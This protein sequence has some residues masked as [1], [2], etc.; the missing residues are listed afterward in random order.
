MVI[1][2]RYKKLLTILAVLSIPVIAYSSLNWVQYSY[3]KNVKGLNNAF[4]PIAIEDNEAS[5]LQ[6][7]IFSTSGSFKKRSGFT[8][9][10]DDRYGATTGIKYVKFSDGKEQI[11]IISS[12]DK[13]Y[14]MDYGSSG[15][16]GIL[17]DITGGLSFSIGQNNLASFAVGENTVVIE[18]GLNTTPPMA[19]HD[20]AVSCVTLAGS[21]PNATVVAYHKNQGFCAGNSAY[22]STLYFT[23]VGNLLNWTTGLSGNIDVEN[24]DGSIIRALV[25][26]FDALYIFKDNSIFRLTGDDKDNFQLQRMVQGIGV[27]SSQAV[28]LIG[29]QFFLTTGQGEVYIYDGAVGVTKISNK[30]EGSLKIN[31]AYSRYP[32]LSTLEYLDDYYLSVSSSSSGTNDTV[33]MFDTFNMA[34]TKFSGINSNAW[35]VFDDGTGKDKILFGNY[36][37]TIL[38][39]PE[40]DNDNGSAIDAYYI[41]KQFSYPELG[42][43]KD[44]KTLRVYAAQEATDYNLTVTTYKDFETTGTETSIDLK[45]TTGG[46]YGT[47]VYGTDVYGGESI[48]ISR[49]EVNLD[50]DFYKIKFS[51]SNADQPF[52]VYGYQMYVEKTEGNI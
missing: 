13:V 24:N 18:D 8:D 30:I 2:K 22:P 7:I 6:N 36:H 3:F 15:P 16:D 28:S 47:A 49:I 17:D 21:P 48:N 37:G 11:F 32:Y 33:F 14:K 35:T 12:D 1:L 38:K 25:P 27:M 39:Y 20:E 23:D 26:G 46:S 42:P 44:W 40:G 5:D 9:I 19:Y 34:W 43:A 52:E 29:N 50:A 41:T 31:T 51:N 4:S 10:N 45:S